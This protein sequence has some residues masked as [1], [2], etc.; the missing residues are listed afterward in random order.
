[1]RRGEEISR[2]MYRLK[3]AAQ[4]ARRVFLSEAEEIKKRE[5]SLMA[6]STFA[7]CRPRQYEHS[8]IRSAA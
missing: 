8:V 1:M 3:P 7:P 4:E 2:R 5:I 6:G